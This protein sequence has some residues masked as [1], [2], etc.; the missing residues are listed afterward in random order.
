MWGMMSNYYFNRIAT[1]RIGKSS[2]NGFIASGLRVEFS[3][4]KTTKSDSNKCQLTIYNLS[5][6]YSSRITVNDGMIVELM[7]GYSDSIYLDLTFIGDVISISYDES[8]PDK[9][10]TLEL[11]DGGLLIRRHVMSLSLKAGSTLKDVFKTI[12]SKQIGNY[13]NNILDKI[14]NVTL[15]NGIS[16]AGYTSD[17]LNVLC[18]SYNLEWSIQNGILQ[19]TKLSEYV[20]NNPI[21]IRALQTPKRIYANRAKEE[22][23]KNFNGYEIKCLLAAKAVPGGTIKIGNTKYKV[24]HVKHIGDTH[25]ED[26]ESTITVKDIL[27]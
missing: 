6:Y 24:M 20:V 21:E 8:N 1:V 18:K 12:L 14:P 16:H 17:F 4:T 25:G 15:K 27:Q 9:S 7:T 10:I 5:K 26:W 23:D 2:Q 13:Q 19:V 11:E 22:D 3:I